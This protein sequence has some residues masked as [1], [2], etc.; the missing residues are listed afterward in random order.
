MGNIIKAAGIQVTPSRTKE[1]T[2]ERS[3][4]LIKLAKKEG[5]VIA[6]LPQMFSTRWF[7]SKINEADFAL[8]ED[9]NGPTLKALKALALSERIT[10]IAPI[11]EQDGARRFSTAFTIGPDGDIIGKYRKVH[12]P[13]LPLWEEKTYFMPGDL[14]FPVFNT[15]AG[16]VGVLLCWDIFFPEAFRVLALKGAEIIFVPTASAFK[17]SIPK[18]ERAAMAAAHANGC[19]VFR[20]NRVGAEAEQ[21]F[22]G[23]SFCAGPDGE[24]IVKPAGSSEGVVIAN[25]DTSIIGAIRNEWVFLKDRRPECYSMIS[26]KK[27]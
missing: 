13:A 1:E 17:H 26:E 19:F 4:E 14:G 20:V 12:V 2:V 6:C 25:I 10:I 11:F 16:T 7:P 8:A 22:Y 5:A 23:S 15:P 3:L 9:E 24:F 21:S 27:K 18:W